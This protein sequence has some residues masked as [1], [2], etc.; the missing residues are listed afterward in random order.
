MSKCPS[1]NTQGQT[2]TLISDRADTS[3][4]HTAYYKIIFS[5]GLKKIV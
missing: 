2:Q 1:F 3:H 4:T 5:K